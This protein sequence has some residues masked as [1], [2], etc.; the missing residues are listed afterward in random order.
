LASAALLIGPYILAAVL[1][2]GAIIVRNRDLGSTTQFWI[3]LGG[4]GLLSLGWTGFLA[5]LSRSD[6]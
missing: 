2:A 5:V 4:A 3:M 1:A 6:L